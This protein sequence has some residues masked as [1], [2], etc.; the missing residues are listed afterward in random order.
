MTIPQELGRFQVSRQLSIARY[1]LILSQLL[2]GPKMIA[3]RSPLDRRESH[4]TMLSW[5]PDTGMLDVD[6]DGLGEI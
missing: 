3:V 2:Q 1:P 5:H 6:P 4:D